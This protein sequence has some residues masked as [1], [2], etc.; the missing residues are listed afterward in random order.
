MTGMVTMAAA[1]V[2]A[3]GTAAYGAYSQS[4]LAG[5]AESQ[6]GTVFGEQQYYAQQ[7]Q[8]LIANPSSVTSLPGY[9]FNQQ[10]GSQAVAR[11][12]AG[13]GFLNSGNEATALTQYGQ[14]YATSAYTTQAN[15]LASLAGLSSST[16]PTAGLNS[17]SN[18]TANATNSLGGLGGMLAFMSGQNSGTSGLNL[19]M[20]NGSINPAYAPEG[21]L[22][23]TPVFGGS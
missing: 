21:G 23:S 10:Q 7:L 19:T 16:N 15:L 9:A 3:A 12:M 8:Q 17:A 4:Q 5:Q 22:V 18:S 14:N 1:A 11:Q 6:S 2:V 13:S 20:N